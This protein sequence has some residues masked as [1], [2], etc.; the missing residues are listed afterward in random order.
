MGFLRCLENIDNKDALVG[1]L[2]H[3]FGPTLMTEASG[4][5]SKLA[6]IRS[7]ILLRG[8]HT[9]RIAPISVTLVRDI[10]HGNRQRTKH[11]PP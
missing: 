2:D 3:Y 8:Q 5:S 11:I 10:T 4:I 6:S 7:R 1:S 9:E